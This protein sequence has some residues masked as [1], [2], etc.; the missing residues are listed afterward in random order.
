MAGTRAL[1]A[2]IGASVALVAAAALALLTISA[3]VAFGGWAESNTVSVD[4]PELVFAGSP[5]SSPDSDRIARRAKSPLVVRA[6]E[7]RAPRR[8]PAPS[9]RRETPVRETPRDTNGG[10]REGGGR[11][12]VNPVPAPPPPPPS[13]KPERETAGDHVSKVGESLSSTVQGTGSALAEATQPLAPPVSA[14]VQQV[15]N[16][17]AELVRRAGSGLGGAVDALVPPR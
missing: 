9:T 2:S 12:R 3:V 10:V 4:R 13:D 8:S 1:F 17:V 14:A 6:P 7:K 5:L 16:I 11:P 15:L